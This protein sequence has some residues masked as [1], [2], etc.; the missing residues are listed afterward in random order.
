M[1]RESFDGGGEQMAFIDFA[2][3]DE[4][5]RKTDEWIRDNH[6]V[7]LWMIGKANWYVTNRMR[8]SISRLVEEARYTK[9]V[10]GINEYKIDNT[11]RAPLARRLIKAVPNCKPYIIT[12]FSL[13]EYAE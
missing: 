9:P 8:F 13:C 10:N 6:A 1:M 2:K 11:L 12:K 4:M 7:W 5:N 3:A